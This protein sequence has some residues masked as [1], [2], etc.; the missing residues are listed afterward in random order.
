MKKVNPRRHPA[1]M[2]DVNKAKKEAMQEA[3]EATSLM[4]YSVLGDKMGFN[5]RQ[6]RQVWDGVNDLADS[7]DE[8]RISLSDLRYVIK[9]DYR[10][11]F[12]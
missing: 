8:G 6:M 7:I 10:I 4:F 12:K 5:Q 1:T 9:T 3:V 11:V 2:A